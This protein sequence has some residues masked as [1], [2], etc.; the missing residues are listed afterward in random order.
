MET[1]SNLEPL[2]TSETAKGGA[3]EALI[4]AAERL[5]SEKGYQEV[6]TRELADAAGVN[7][8]AI[9]YHFG[10]KAALFI[11]T[12]KSMM[13]GNGCVRSHMGLDCEIHTREEAGERLYLFVH[14]FLDYLIR[15]EGPQACRLMFREMLSSTAC[16]QE[17]FPVLVSSV[18]EEYIKPL[19]GTL[20]SVLQIIH[21][22]AS[23]AELTRTSRSIVGQCSFYLTHRPFIEE[24]D[25]RDFSRTADFE[26]VLNHIVRFSLRGLRCDEPFIDSIIKRAQKSALHSPKNETENAHDHA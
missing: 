5:F 10:S 17:M 8:G 21:P 16:N 26:A 2:L 14:S 13:Q 9:Q 6:S 15:P 1:E 7:L 24:L 19:E 25:R 12:I 20:V 23:A 18:V 4:R 11:A 22:K 3:R